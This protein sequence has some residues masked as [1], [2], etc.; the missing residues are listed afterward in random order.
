[1]L[2][3]LL[4]PAMIFFCVLVGGVTIAAFFAWIKHAHPELLG[5]MSLA[6]LGAASFGAVSLLSDS[7]YFETLSSETASSSGTL[8][9]YEK[10]SEMREIAPKIFLG[11]M[12]IWLVLLLIDRLRK[13]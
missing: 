6:A 2:L 7:G 1:M 12:M 8:G 5:F 11:L 9:I 3:Y 13:S 10:M 4:T